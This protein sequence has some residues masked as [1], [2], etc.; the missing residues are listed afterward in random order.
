MT[1]REAYQKYFR[2]PFGDRTS[3]GLLSTVV[4]ADKEKKTLEGQ[5]REK[6]GSWKFV[7]LQKGNCKR[8]YVG[9]PA[10]AY[11]PADNINALQCSCTVL[12]V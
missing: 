3:P 8:G 6:K 5:P 12:N 7:I 10:Y 1:F 11:F 4:S 2:R 9:V